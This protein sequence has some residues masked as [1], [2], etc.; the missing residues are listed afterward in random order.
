MSQ[1]DTIIKVLDQV[2]NL[3]LVW[4]RCKSYK[5]RNKTR[6]SRKGLRS[7]KLGTINE[8]Y[9]IYEKYEINEDSILSSGTKFFIFTILCCITLFGISM[10]VFKLI[11]PSLNPNE[12]TKYILLAIVT[13][14]LAVIFTVLAI[15]NM[16]YNLSRFLFWI[17]VCTISSSLGY[18]LP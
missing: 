15:K 9:E 13:S 2:S 12:K 16:D 3:P 7:N 11:S 14:V 4:N 5:T 6:V 1:D 10:A 17:V 8:K 18:F